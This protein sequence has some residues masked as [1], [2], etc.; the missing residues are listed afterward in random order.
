M[1]GPRSDTTLRVVVTGSSGLI[2]TALVRS[3]RGDGHEVVRLVRRN[4]SAPDE[5][6]WD[7]ARRQLDPGVLDGA[8]AVVHLAGVGVGDHRWSDAHKHAVRA[9]RVDGTATVAA[10][11]AAL[12]ATSRPRVLVSASAVGFYGDTGEEAV[13]ESAPSGA[14]FLAGVVREWE[15][16]AAPAADAGARVVTPRSGIV[17][18]TDGG[19]LGRVLPL[20]R[21]GLGGR[22]GS[23]RQWMS[24]IAMPD[25]I[26]ALRFRSEERRV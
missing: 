1:T 12:P 19:A 23:G 16:A 26:A 17:L 8:D 4:P 13:D 25:E 18:S 11:V 14:G 24:W 7:P 2:G 6:E 3:L 10:A 22:L 5:R 9:S 15:A 20:F 21:L